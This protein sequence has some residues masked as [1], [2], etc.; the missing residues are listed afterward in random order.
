MSQVTELFLRYP[1]R[2]TTQS[3]APIE[4]SLQ[5]PV[6]ASGKILSGEEYWRI[7]HPHLDTIQLPHFP[8]DCMSFLKPVPGQSRSST[9][10]NQTDMEEE[11]DEGD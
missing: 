9:N 3:N 1:T 5:S 10:P 2:P 4:H 6:P 8:P 11:F 7:V